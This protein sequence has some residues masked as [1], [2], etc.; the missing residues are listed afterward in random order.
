VY[1][2]AREYEDTKWSV[3]QVYKVPIMSTENLKEIVKEKEEQSKRYRSCDAYWLLVVVDFIDN[4]QDQEIRI[5]GFEKI[6]S[7]I[8]EK[9]VVYK[10][11]FGH[12]LE[13]K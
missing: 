9:I 11:T 12:V 5:D 13:A 8:F 6:D 1:L 10:T 4:A 3:A 7:E 2:N